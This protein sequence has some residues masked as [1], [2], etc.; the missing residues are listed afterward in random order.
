MTSNRFLEFGQANKQRNRY[1]R[2]ST[3][4]WTKLASSP[5]L[6]SHS[7]IRIADRAACEGVLRAH[8]I[9]PQKGW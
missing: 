9:G 8:T 7:D 3:R 5:D 2:S 4:L 1:P 6:L